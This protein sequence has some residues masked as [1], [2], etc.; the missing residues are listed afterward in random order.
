MR[1]PA[2]LLGLLLVAGCGVLAEAL[3]DE[4]QAVEKLELLGGEVERDDKLP[5]HP[6]IA[7]SFKERNRFSDNYVHLLES[8]AHL[9]R[10]DFRRAK[11]TDAGLKKLGQLKNLTTLQLVGTPITDAGLKELGGLK[12]L[13]TLDLSYTGITDAGLKEVGKLTNLTTLKLAKFSHDALITD[14][15]LTALSNLK[16]LTTL[17]LV[18]TKI[19]D[20]GVKELKKSLPH[21]QISR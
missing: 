13:T 21:V 19:T 10:V 3:F 7:V 18:G 5:G 11:I 4:S 20:A 15:G 14:A 2:A 9:T 1:I 8:F 12:N 16:N 17:D 6:V